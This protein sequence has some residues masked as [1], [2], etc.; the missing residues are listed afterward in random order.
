MA[1]VE[2]DFINFP[3]VIGRDLN[4]ISSETETPLAASVKRKM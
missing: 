3:A 4:R 1:R 2:Y